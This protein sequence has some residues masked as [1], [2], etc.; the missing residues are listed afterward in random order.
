MEVSPEQALL[1]LAENVPYIFLGGAGSKLQVLIT[2]F[3]E[4]DFSEVLESCFLDHFNV[5]CKRSPVPQMNGAVVGLVSYD[6]FCCPKDETR[7]TSRVFLVKSAICFLNNQPF[8]QGEISEHIRS[9]IGK[10]VN[11]GPH[12]RSV[13]NFVLKPSITDS[14]YIANVNKVRQSILDGRYYQLNL[15]RY[16]DVEGVTGEKSVLQRFF[17]H[18]GSQGAIFSL[19]DEKVFSFSPERF[20]RLSRV[21][22]GQD[23]GDLSVQ[24]WPIKGTRPRGQNKH[25]DD[26]LKAELLS[27][28]KDR[29]ELH[30]IVDLMRNDFRRLARPLSVKVDD[31]GSVVSFNSVN[32]LMA[33]LS[34][35]MSVKTRLRDFFRCLLPAGSI[36]GAPKLEVMRAIREFE[37]RSRGWFMGSAFYLSPSGQFDSS[38]LIRTLHLGKDGR[39]EYAA[40]SG[41]VVKSEAFEELEEIK[42]KCSVLT[43]KI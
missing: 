37:G 31:P 2:D 41:L 32:H 4:I 25:E 16:F 21:F 43:E 18:S 13:A 42:T 23:E 15:L 9:I 34:C 27:S 30:M 24:T 36:T 6:D 17:Q 40:G 20:V 8:E 10:P 5:T 29:A 12:K 38:V 3:E 33:K 26:L 1:N 19:P 35:T 7:I 14:H 22:S 28:K 11:H 39:Y